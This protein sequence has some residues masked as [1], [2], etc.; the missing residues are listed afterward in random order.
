MA[1]SAAKRHKTGESEIGAPPEGAAAVPAS[2]GNSKR[3]AGKIILVTGGTQGCGEGIL[4]ACA[5]EGAAGLVFCGRQ[6]E[7]GAAVQASLEAKGVAALYVK[8]DLCVAAEV[9]NVVTLAD[10][11]FGRI[12]GLV[13]CAADTTRGEWTGENKATV[14]LLDR[15]YALNFRAPF[16]VYMRKTV[17]FSAFCI[18]KKDQFTK[19]ASGQT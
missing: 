13:N 3:L 5:D 11:K 6:E 2:E 4:H 18:P 17:L 7:L 8:A 12:D 10:D 19:T 1:E 16:L 14:E 15:Q 9:Q